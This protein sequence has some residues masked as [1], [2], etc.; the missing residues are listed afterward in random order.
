RRAVVLCPDRGWRREP[1]GAYPNPP[2]GTLTVSI[3]TC[4]THRMRTTRQSVN[5]L[6]G[7]TA[8]RAGLPHVHPHMLRHSCGFTL[9]NRGY[10]LRLIQDYLGHRDPKHTVHYT[11]TAGHRFEGLWR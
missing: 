8:P 4:V 6:I 9:A 1:Q 10:D 2:N 11:R 5:S 3:R 7:A